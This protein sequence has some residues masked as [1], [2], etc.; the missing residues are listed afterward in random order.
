MK[1]RRG[2]RPVRARRGMS[3]IEVLL[4]LTISAVLLTA[5]LVALDVMF[6]RYTVIGDSASSN[7][8]ARTVMHRMLAMIRTGQEF[9]PYPADPLDPD[10]NPSDSDRLE[11][12]SAGV[13]GPG[14][15]E[16]T[17][18]ELRPA[19]A[20]VIEG[21]TIQLRGPNVLWMTVLTRAGNTTTA[22][23]TFPL[24]DGVAACNF[25]LDFAPGPRLVRATI[26]LTVLPQG[27]ATQREIEG[28]TFSSETA[29]GGVNEE[30][31]TTSAKQTIRLIAS[32]G[33][34]GQ[35]E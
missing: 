17:T 25:N 35:D 32:T 34:R 6:K 29:G 1:L 19:E 9:G 11:F 8:L 20:V 22:T 3:I 24:L 15:Y 31:S 2:T 16:I 13:R 14:A 23:N 21:E 5:A 33:P 30:I 18:I 27:G 26:D 10:Q 7:V 12:I 28:G 4:A